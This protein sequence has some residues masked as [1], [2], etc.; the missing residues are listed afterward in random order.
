MPK[1]TFEPGHSAAEFSVRHMMVTWV[2][3]FF[4]NVHGTLDFDLD[5]PL[6]GSLKV[7]IDASK[8]WTGEADR[9]G[10]LRA[11]A[12]LD[13]EKHPTITYRGKFVDRIGQNEFKVKG[14]LAIKGVT[15]EV[16]MDVRYLG[17]WPTPWWEGG[18]DIGP[19]IRAGFVANTVVNRHDFGVS[20]NGDLENGGVVVGSDVLI[21]VDAE[22]IL[23]D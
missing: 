7:D 8:I 12:F 10:H 15:R 16:Q 4:P 21:R 18:K 20:W 14:D 11:A 2:R 9:D 5:H 17:Q 3:G 1:W 19:K 22:A 13:V 6:D 23:D